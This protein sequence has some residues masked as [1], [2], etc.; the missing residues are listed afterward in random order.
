MITNLQKIILSLFLISF[1]ANCLSFNKE[2]NISEIESIQDFSS[3]V[4][5]L[6]SDKDYLKNEV[7]N[8]NASKPAIQRIVFEA[9]VL[10]EKGNL[11]DAS[12]NLERAL[13]L[14]TIE[15]SIYLRL[16]HIR[17]EQGLIKESQGFAARGLLIEN[18]SSWEKV[19]LT[20][21]LNIPLSY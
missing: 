18:I 13:R 2:I 1:L 11:Q 6:L 3:S 12:F 5:S 20:V 19:L 21:Y 14:S 9:D 15:P 7:K 4:I 8:I 10:W 17:L 16:A